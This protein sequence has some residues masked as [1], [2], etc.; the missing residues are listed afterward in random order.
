[1]ERNDNQKKCFRDGYYPKYHPQKGHTSEATSQVVTFQI[2][3]TCKATER[4]GRADY[5]QYH[6]LNRDKNG[7]TFSPAKPNTEASAS[8]ACGLNF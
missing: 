1:M 4:A 2:L 5:T 3:E 7:I 8:V 6:H